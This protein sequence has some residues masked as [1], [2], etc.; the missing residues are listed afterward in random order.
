[1]AGT[2]VTDQIDQRFLVCWCGK[3]KAAHHVQCDSCAG[4]TSSPSA[5]ELRIVQSKPVVQKLSPLAVR[6]AMGKSM[7]RRVWWTRTRVLEGLQR[8]HREQGCAP[9][10]TAEYHRMTKNSG[11]GPRRRYPSFYAVLRHFAT[12]REAWTASGVDV[13]RAW[14]EWSD[15]ENWYM[16]EAIGLI[17]RD[18][19][20]RDLKRSDAAVKRH[21]YDL[22]LLIRTA[23]GWSISRIEKATGVRAHVLKRYMEWG[24]LP[25]FK[26]TKVVYIDPGDL[27]VVQELD[28]H[29]LPQELEEAMIQSLRARLVKVLARQDWRTGRLHQ[30]QPII[31]HRYADPAARRRAPLKPLPRPNDI[32]PGDWVRVVEDV[33]GRQCMGRVGL[34]HLVYPA[35]ARFS[36]IRTQGTGAVWMARV[37]FK[38]M[39]RGPGRTAPRVTYSLPL[40]ALLKDVEPPKPE[41]PNGLELCRCGSWRKPSRDMCW[42]C[43]EVMHG[44]TRRGGAA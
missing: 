23:R 37:E 2:G 17:P 44:K 34:V 29:H 38:T 4:R 28:F 25:Y 7:H 19:I 13:D 16:R 12:F 33:P 10:A 20:A 36:Y 32:E 39:R 11:L 21:L 43:R 1:M 22:A 14:E 8:F 6:R 9:T 5:V 35:N 27:I 26:G 41:S 31:V 3:P 15:L 42:R 30:S 40:T 24:D 18:E